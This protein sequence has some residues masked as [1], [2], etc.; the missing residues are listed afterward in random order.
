MQISDRQSVANL[1]RNSDGIVI[2]D[3]QITNGVE[4][5]TNSVENLFVTDLRR[6]FGRKPYFATEIRRKF[7]WVIE[8]FFVVEGVSDYFGRAL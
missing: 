1:W 4:S 3:Q 8:G 6:H 5:V 2:S 7:P